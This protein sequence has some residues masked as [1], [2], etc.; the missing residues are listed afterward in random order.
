MFQTVDYH[1][2]PNSVS[3][4]VI[5]GDT[6]YS[7]ALMYGSSIGLILYYNP[8][9]DPSNL[10]IGTVLCVP[11]IQ[12][13][14]GRYHLVEPGDT[15]Y[16]VSQLYGIPVED[17]MA[18]NP[19]VDPYNMMPGTIICLPPS[20]SCPIG[21]PYVIQD[22]DTYYLIATRYDVSYNDMMTA[23][24]NFDYDNLESGD[25]ICIPESQPSKTCEGDSYIMQPG[26]TLSSVAEATQ[27]SA[28]QIL[29]VNPEMIPSE[30]VPGRLICIP[31]TTVPV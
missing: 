29:V 1:C 2:P 4:M 10:I 11:L 3:H 15:F 6:L 19:N 8:G 5:P 30:F 12:C 7:I 21:T 26:D 14:E 16:S 23:N 27:T 9:I 31:T 25:T 17:L 18:Y 20:D 13:P 22:T 24:E 28:E